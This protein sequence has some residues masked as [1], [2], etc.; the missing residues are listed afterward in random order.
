MLK[1]GRP[2]PVN[3]PSEGQRRFEIPPPRMRGELRIK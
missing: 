2:S 3:H 1:D